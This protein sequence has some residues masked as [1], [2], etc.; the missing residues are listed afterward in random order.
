MQTMSE[1]LDEHII[2]RN[3]WPPRSPDLSFGIFEGESLQKQP[4][5]IRIVEAKY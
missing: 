1:L 3:L 5:H 2:F 4:A